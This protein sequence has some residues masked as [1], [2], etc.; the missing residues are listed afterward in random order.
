MFNKLHLLI[1][2]YMIWYEGNRLRSQ[3]MIWWIMKK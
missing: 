1:L 3:T 2:N